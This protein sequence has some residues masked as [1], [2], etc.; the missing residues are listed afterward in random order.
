MNYS[1]LALLANTETFLIG[2]EDAEDVRCKYVEQE[3]VRC[4]Y[5]EQENKQPN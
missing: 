1:M 2:D 3:D 5:A 4:Q